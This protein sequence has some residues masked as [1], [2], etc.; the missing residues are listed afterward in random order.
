MIIIWQI[1]K[2]NIHSHLFGHVGWIQALSFRN[3]NG[4]ILASVDDETVHVWN[5]ISGLCLHQLPVSHQFFFS[6][7]S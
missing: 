6:L 5:I 4:S 3:D 2:L 1:E 7:Y